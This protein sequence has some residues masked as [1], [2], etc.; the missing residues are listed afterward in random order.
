MFLEKTHT[1]NMVDLPPR[2]TLIGCICIFNIKTHSN[3][4][5]KCCKARLVAKGY[6]QK[7]GINNKEVFVPVARLTF[8][9][10]LVAI[11][12]IRKWSLL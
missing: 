10:W 7:Y 6:S 5:V 4:P 12:A 8:V 2:K 1:R 3:G 11:T 9:Q